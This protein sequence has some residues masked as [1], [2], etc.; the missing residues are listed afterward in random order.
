MSA[1]RS[2]AASPLRILCVHGVGRHPT[3]GPWEGAWQRSIEEPLRQIA[4]DVQADIRFVYLDDIFD[5][6]EIT[7]LDVLEAIGK[8]G[9]A[10][11]AAAL[12]QPRGLGD[13]M[14]WTAGMVVQWVE[15]TRLRRLTRQRLAARIEE[16]QP[17]LIVA[18][19]LGSLVAYDTFTAPGGESLVR[20]RRFV[21]AGSQIG[22]PFVVGQFALG[23]LTAL[24]AAEFWY[25]LY[26]EEDDVFTA[27][28]RLSAPNFAQIETAFDIAGLADH[29][30]TCYM[31]HP[32]TVSTVWADA[33][34]ALQ[35]QPLSRRVEPAKVQA[36]RLAKGQGRWATT[37]S[38]RALIVGV[39]EYADA[40]QNLSG[41]VNDAFLV[42]AMLQESGF[43]AGDIRMVLN[44]RATCA[45]VRDRLEWLLDGAKAG[46]TRFL[47]YSG[48]GAQMPAYGVGERVDSV[49][50]TLVLHD[51]DWT[52]E[53]AFTDEQFHALYSQLP[54]EL[55]FVAMFDCCHSGGM[56]RQP[57]RRVRGVDAPDDIRHR[58][59]RWVPEREMWVPRDF[60]APSP[61]FD[62][63]FNAGPRALTP[64][65]HRLGQAMSLRAHD[66]AAFKRLAEARGHKGPYLPVLMYASRE[67]QFS[68]EYQHGAVAHGAFTYCLVKT[69]RNSRRLGTP[70][71]FESLTAQVGRELAELGYEQDPTLVAPSHVKTMNVPLR[72]PG[73]EAVKGRARS[74]RDGRRGGGPAASGTGAGPRRSAGR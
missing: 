40:A 8:L 33:A 48:H 21:S 6:F 13:E 70:L 23:R 7:P 62:R 28:A 55:N 45:G 4:P 66:G 15:D 51:F 38:R 60:K 24:D 11:P 5:R 41:C 2:A 10:V 39:N 30:V 44:D 25:H 71:S 22:H 56:T 14:R 46:D 59:L 34:M 72:T 57:G 37:P 20:G 54:Y 19:S 47:Y 52:A 74:S 43:D 32:R 29:D 12:R 26:N 64:S 61:G 73:P 42:S 17:H 31:R 3:G 1:T 16:V 35:R 68:F 36:A 27:E 65:T 49:H 53:R 18:H 9:A 69:L 67:D 58:M 50:E 63:K